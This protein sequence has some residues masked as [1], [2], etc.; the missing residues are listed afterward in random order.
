M[1]DGGVACN[2]GDGGAPAVGGEFGGNVAWYGGE[3]RVGVVGAD[4]ACLGGGVRPPRHNLSAVQARC[5][6]FFFFSRV[7]RRFLA[8]VEGTVPGWVVVRQ[9]W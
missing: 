1:G 6:F 8:V 4:E 2:M 5:A 3:V 7:A 9:Y